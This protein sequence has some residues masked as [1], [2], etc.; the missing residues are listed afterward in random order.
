MDVEL[1]SMLLA[2][3]KRVDKRMFFN[4]FYRLNQILR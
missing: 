2:E 3:I 4:I 1:K